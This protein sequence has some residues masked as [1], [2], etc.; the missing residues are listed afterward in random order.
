MRPSLLSLRQPGAS[1]KRR[2]QRGF[3]LI[4]LLVVLAILALLAGVAAPQVIRY[5]GGAKTDTA[6]LDVKN[7]ATALD[8]YRLEVGRYP[9]NEEGLRALIAAPAGVRGWNGP[10]LR[11]E[12]MLVD[13]WGRPY[14][15]THPGQHGDFDL[16]SLG[17]DDRPGGSGEDQDVT[18]WQ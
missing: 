7:I 1:D 15:Y 12:S 17:A 2:R 13:P 9:S 3:T 11:S 10:Y 14:R 5:L 8:L 6:R 16:Y 18:S 4:E